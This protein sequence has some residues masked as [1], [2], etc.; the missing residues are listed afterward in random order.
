MVIEIKRNASPDEVRRILKKR[1][2]TG[3]K[4]KRLASFFGKLPNI[5]DGLKYQ[6]KVRN[7]W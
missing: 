4:K 2:A 6:K 3:N 7:E 1:K 5:G